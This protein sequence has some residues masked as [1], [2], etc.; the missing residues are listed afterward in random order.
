MLNTHF[1]VANCENK[2]IGFINYN[3]LK[4]DNI[5]ELTAFY[6][7]PLFQ[8]RGIGSSLFEK[9]IIDL[10]V[11]TEILCDVETD[12]HKGSSFY[13]KKGFVIEKQFIEPFMGFDLQTTRM[14]YKV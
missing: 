13:V 3:L 14:K 1:H 10:K 2:I 6:V 9:M 8:R 11:G 7:N 5:V 4:G 12:N